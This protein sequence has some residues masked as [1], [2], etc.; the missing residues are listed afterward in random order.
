MI[1]KTELKGHY[2]IRIDVTPYLTPPTATS[3]AGGESEQGG[4]LD[5]V[6][7]LFTGFR[8]QLGLQRKREKIPSI[9]GSG[10]RE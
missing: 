1:D 5:P 9:T 8:E 4:D 7:L 6:S 10:L 2:D 3:G